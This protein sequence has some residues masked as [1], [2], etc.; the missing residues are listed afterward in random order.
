MQHLHAGYYYTLAGAVA[1]IVLQVYSLVSLVNR[2]NADL[3]KFFSSV[4]DHDTSIRFS[5][6]NGNNSFSKLHDRMNHLNTIIQNAKI[7]NERTSLFLQ[8]VVNHVD[9]GLL[10]FDS[11]GKIEIS[12]HAVK[13]FLNIQIFQH[14]SKLKEAN[15]DIYN[16]IIGIKPKQEVMHKIVINNSL[17]SILIKATELKFENNVI[18][19]VSFQDITNELDK[20]EFESWQRLIRVLTHEIMNSISP[21]TSLTSVISG[22]FKNKED[23][24]PILPDKINEQIISKTLLGLNTI[25]ETGKGLLEFVDKYRKLTSLPKPNASKFGIDSLF[26]K[27]KLLMGSTIPSTIEINAT[28]SPE[29]ISLYADYAQIEQVLINLIKNAIESFDNKKNGTIQLH[30]FYNEGAVLIQVEDNG[31]GIPDDNMENIFVPFY[32]TKESGSGIG[33]SLSKQIM[34][35]HNGTLSVSSVQNMGSVFTLRFQF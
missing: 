23:K 3:E 19:L 7:K 29:D 24:N 26:Q 9:V 1:L 6:N 16:I 31:I 22:Y 30:A 34:Q 15:N 25:E 5:E 17:H 35:N 11:S 14:L 2:T 18:K 28:V 33:L 32:T 8:S 21:I 12:N 27:C 20:K 10:S 4:Q 13:K